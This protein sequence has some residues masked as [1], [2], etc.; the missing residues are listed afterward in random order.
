MGLIEKIQ[1]C[2]LLKRLES[3]LDGEQTPVILFA[4]GMADV[5]IIAPNV[6]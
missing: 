3:L 6:S 1:M 2:E 5:T 4:E